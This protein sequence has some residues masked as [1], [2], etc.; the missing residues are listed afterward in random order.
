M[1]QNFDM[2]RIPTIPT[3]SAELHD[4]E[5][6][7]MHRGG[8]A[9][10]LSRLAERGESTRADILRA[11]HEEIIERGAVKMTVSS[12]AARAGVTRTLFY[13]YFA[14]KEIAAAAV[15]EAVIDDFLA[16][17]DEWNKARVVGD[18]NKALDDVIILMRRIIHADGPFHEGLASGG[19]ADLYMRFVS[20]TAHRIASYMEETTVR[21][22]A[23]HHE[24]KISNV[25]ET[26]YTL[27][28]GLLSLIRTSPE[29]SDTVIK[30]VAAQSLHIDHLVTFSGSPSNTRDNDLASTPDTHARE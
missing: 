2:Q 14:D 8:N 27:I 9:R 13:H 15:I 20:R 29:I 12:I 25:H 22:F 11:V 5:R 10:P 19:N 3:R 17:L 23:E 7:S 28:V 24:M 30:H 16:Q 4:V 6:A 21:D 1:A 26:F 18:V